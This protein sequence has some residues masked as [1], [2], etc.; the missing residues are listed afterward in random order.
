VQIYFP[1]VSFP[2]TAG[3]TDCTSHTMI[4]EV[5]VA[6]YTEAEGRT[7][8]RSLAVRNMALYG[9]LQGWAK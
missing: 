4:S 2:R 3:S 5:L 1:P 8:P 9:G 6:G 7:I